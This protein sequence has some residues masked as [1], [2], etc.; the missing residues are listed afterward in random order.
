MVQA[1][2]GQSITRSKSKT[3]PGVAGGV[4]R[5][6]SDISSESDAFGFGGNAEFFWTPRKRSTRE[7]KLLVVLRIR[8]D[9][10]RRTRL[11]SS[12]ASPALRWP[13]SGRFAASL[14]LALQ[15]L[16]QILDHLDVRSDALGL[17]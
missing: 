17:N 15:L 2:C 11:S 7:R 3:P 14:D 8:R 16:R 12:S 6:A 13:R 1:N 10:G 5:G 4:L 9:V